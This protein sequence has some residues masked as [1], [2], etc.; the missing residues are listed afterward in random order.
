MGTRW[1][2]F[3]LG[4]T[5]AF[6]EILK[7]GG[8]PSAWYFLVGLH[9]A[10]DSIL[11]TLPART[12]TRWAGEALPFDLCAADNTHFWVIIIVL[13]YYH[14]VVISKHCV[15][16]RAWM[17]AMTWAA[18]TR[19]IPSVALKHTNYSMPQLD[20]RPCFLVSQITVCLNCTHVRAF[21]WA[22]AAQRCSN[23]SN[24]TN[25]T[26]YCKSFYLPSLIQQHLL[27]CHTPL[28]STCV[29]YFCVSDSLFLDD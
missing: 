10:D 22:T 7:K 21:W 17:A 24:G 4:C 3:V 20:A 15:E 16:R 13:L 25:F 27:T 8:Q 9:A 19:A 23:N 26:L 11:N 12:T 28:C 1:G 5:L 18:M 29:Y 14:L 6:T 2:A